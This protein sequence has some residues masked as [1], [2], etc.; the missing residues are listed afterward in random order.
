[1]AGRVQHIATD[2]LTALAFIVR[3]P[4]DHSPESTEDQLALAH[5]ADC[6]ECAARF[7]TLVTSADALRDAACAAADDVFDD[8]MLD[9]QRTRILD[10]LAHLGPGRPGPC[11]PSP[12]TRSHHAGDFQQPT[13]D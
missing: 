2:R 10:R 5:V 6:D 3:A 4:E 1:M 9:A 11:L 12:P 8:A 7:A 13:L